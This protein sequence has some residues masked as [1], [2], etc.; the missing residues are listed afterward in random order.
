MKKCHDSETGHGRQRRETT[1]N[2]QLSED[3]SATCRE[4][5]QGNCPIGSLGHNVWIPCPGQVGRWSLNGHSCNRHRNSPEVGLIGRNWNLYGKMPVP[6]IRLERGM[7]RVRL[8]G[9]RQ[10]VTKGAGDGKGGTAAI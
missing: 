1:K 3:R 2:P 10:T 9:V 5:L 8:L 4:T 7:S 6:R